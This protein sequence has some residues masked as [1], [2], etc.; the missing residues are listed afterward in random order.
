M[1]T[2]TYENRTYTVIWVYDPKLDWYIP[3]VTRTN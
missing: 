2:V 3:I 1:D